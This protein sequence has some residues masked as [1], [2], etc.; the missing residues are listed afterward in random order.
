VCTVQHAT[1]PRR[2]HIGSSMDATTNTRL[3]ARLAEVRHVAAVESLGVQSSV[4]RML[5]EPV[6]PLHDSVYLTAP[7]NLLLNTQPA[8]KRARTTAPS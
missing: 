6:C 5:L 2:P 4:N 8:V 1:K 3:G 7:S